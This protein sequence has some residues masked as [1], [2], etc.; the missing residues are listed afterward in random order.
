MKKKFEYIEV[1]GQSK[2]SG[3]GNYYVTA[4]DLD[5]YGELGWELVC[6]DNGTAWMKREITE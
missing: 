1:E 6:I 4:S 5:E 3:W 2:E